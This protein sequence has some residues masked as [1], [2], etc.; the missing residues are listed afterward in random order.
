MTQRMSHTKKPISERTSLFLIQFECVKIDEL[1]LRWKNMGKIGFRRLFFR[2]RVVIV[3]KTC[4]LL[5]ADIRNIFLFPYVHWWCLVCFYLF[6]LFHYRFSTSTSD[7]SSFA[8]WCRS[9]YW[10]KPRFAFV[11]RRWV[12]FFIFVLLN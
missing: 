5:F 8:F 9:L 1:L 4:V 2:L 10:Y 7:Q 3:L 6:S 11:F 12:L